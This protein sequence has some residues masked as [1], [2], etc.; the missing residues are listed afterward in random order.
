MMPVRAT[1]RGDE[2]TPLERDCDVLVCGASFAGLG[3]RARAGGLRRAGARDRPL[4][5]RRAPD[6]GVRDAHGWLRRARS[7]GL[8]RQ[9]L[10]RDRRAHAVP[11]RPLAAAVVV[12]D[13]RLPR[14]VRAAVGARPSR[15]EL[16]FETATVTGRE[17]NT[18][19]TDR[20][21]LTRAADRRRARLAARALQRAADPAARTRGSRAAWR[22]TRRDAARRWSCGSTRATS[23]PATPGASP[24]ATSCASASARSGPPTTSRSRPCR[25]AGEL[26]LPPDGYQGN[27]IPHELRPRRR[28]RRVLR[29]RLRRALPA[30]HRRGH[31][32]GAVLRPRL[33]ARAARGARRTAARASR[34]S[35]RYG[36]FSDAHERKYRW[37]LNAQRAVGQLTPTRAVTAMV[38]RVRE[39]RASAR[40]AVRPLPRDRAAVVRQL[41]RRRRALAGRLAGTSHPTPPSERV[42]PGTRSTRSAI[43]AQATSRSRG[44]HRAQ[45]LQRETAGLDARWPRRPPRAGRPRRPCRRRGTR[46]RR[47]R[48]PAGRARSCRACRA[49]PSARPSPDAGARSRASAPVLERRRR[50]AAPG[51]APPDRRSPAGGSASAPGSAPRRRGRSTGWSSSSARSSPPRPCP[52]RSSGRRGGGAGRGRRRRCAA[53]PAQAVVAE[54]LA[55]LVELGRE[56]HRRALR[57]LTARASPSARRRR[58]RARAARASPPACSSR[59]PDS[60][61]SRAPSAAGARPATRRTPPRARRGRGGR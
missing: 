31:S 54:Q 32:H 56:D 3:R 25:L 17:G 9:T 49:R 10:R 14:A 5:D 22:S 20:G 59:R 18:V 43:H 48:P 40:W 28:G 11:H 2:R 46:R 30:A 27:W 29:R 12:L 50:A 16:E 35:R 23:A 60:A 6:L 7:D 47:D 53:L 4:R 58:A 37:L 41:R 51:A 13:V 33:R 42:G 55:R 38:A 8:L 57:Q 34:R 19:H 61:R 44:L 15:A 52:R 21:E 1:K 39:P 24:P 45:R 26:G 36:A